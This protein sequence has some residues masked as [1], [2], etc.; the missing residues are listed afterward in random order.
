MHKLKNRQ[1]DEQATYAFMTSKSL[2][3]SWVRHL[4]AQRTGAINFQ[5]SSELLKENAT[6]PLCNNSL[7]IGITWHALLSCQ[8]IQIQQLYKEWGQKGE[9]YWTDLIDKHLSVE[10]TNQLLTPAA[11]LKLRGATIRGEQWGGW[12]HE[13]GDIS[14]QQYLILA[15]AFP[16][17]ELKY[18]SQAQ[19]ALTHHN[20]TILNKYADLVGIHKG[21]DNGI[22]II[23][24]LPLT[25]E[26]KL[27]DEAITKTIN[28]NPVRSYTSEQEEQRYENIQMGWKMSS[29]MLSSEDQRYYLTLK[30]D[31]HRQ[32]RSSSNADMDKMIHQTQ[33]EHREQVRIIT[34][35]FLQIFGPST[36]TDQQEPLAQV[37]TQQNINRDHTHL[38]STLG[39]QR[40]RER[41][42][43]NDTLT[44][45]DHIQLVDIVA[46]KNNEDATPPLS[47]SYV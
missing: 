30:Q 10:D 25:Q 23:R 22:R 27:Q 2:Y 37:D 26:Q 3:K 7:S 43:Q 8:H 42:Y 46:N 24:T 20:T 11:L 45:R 13:L 47:A 12:I 31:Q 36:N 18:I 32:G 6:C 40:P 33:P 5:G 9:T 28:T 34:S 29:H 1:I 19:K 38:A 35:P 41:L 15:A 21:A 16:G 44:H 4:W 17:Q 14:H 39:G